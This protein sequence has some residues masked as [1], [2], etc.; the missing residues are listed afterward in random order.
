MKT[1]GNINR[2][3]FMAAAGAAVLVRP[4]L[5]WAAEGDTLVLRTDSDILILDPAFQS[6]AIEEE[7]GCAIF[8]S[9]TRLGATGEPLAWTP[10]AASLLEPVDA[11][12]IRFTLRDGLAWT[13]GYGPVTTED[14]KYS[15]ERIANPAVGSPWHYAFEALDRIDVI[16]AR[17]GVIRL[18]HPYSPFLNASLP[19]WG[20][21][22][23]CKTAVE[24][25]GGRF[26]TEPPATC[27]PYVIDKWEPKQSI[28]LTANPAWPGPS[29]DFKHVR[30]QVIEDDDSALLAFEA[31]A[32]AFTRISL[33]ALASYKKATPPDTTLID[34]PGIRFQWLTVNMD[35]P[36]LKDPRIRRA[37]QRALDIDQILAGAYSDLCKAATGVV[38]PG[39]IGYRGRIL[40][41][42]DKAEAK[43]L[44]KEAGPANLSLE[45]A[46][47]SDQTELLVAQI[48]Q[49]LL[50]DVGIDVLIRAYDEGVYWSLGDRN[51]GDGWKSLELVLMSSTSGVDP[52]ENLNW[53]RPEQI[54]TWNWSAFDS[55][56]FEGLYSQGLIESDPAKRADIYRRMQD[57]MEESG[58]F[59]FISN[60]T[61]AA[62]CRPSIHPFILPDDLTDIS[63]F[64]RASAQETAQP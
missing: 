62:V 14:V 8:P 19:F 4:H 61:Y 39:M 29:P 45:L 40:Y 47:Q 31:R 6:G 11:A 24:K 54:G 59:V 16:D 51:S 28:L 26:T 9:L 64:S 3:Q 37:I 56:E 5:G 2:R 30:F 41:P 32:V 22:I 35:S 36:K 21:H 20:G 55:A 13:G 43:R 49:A 38:L 27:G 52:A 34:M 60:D 48:I 1:F 7:I 25:G 33:N 46:V 44:L 57:L 10:Y 12:T 53:F 17:S 42:Y 23:V 18:K 58:G 15:F 63:R 50:A